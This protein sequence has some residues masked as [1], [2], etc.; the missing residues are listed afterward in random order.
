MG[1]I[2]GQMPFRSVILLNA[3]EIGVNFSD[4]IIEQDVSEWHFVVY[5]CEV[6]DL[7]SDLEKALLDPGDLWVFYGLI[8]PRHLWL[9]SR[10]DSIPWAKIF[11][12]VL[13]IIN[14]YKL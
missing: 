4:S 5:G 7:K 6:N 8:V 9:F 14:R 1:H 2:Y 11:P 13:I 12:K 10:K 3:I